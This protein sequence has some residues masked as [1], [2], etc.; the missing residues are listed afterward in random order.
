MAVK[1]TMMSTIG[2]FTATTASS[3]APYCGGLLEKQNNALFYFT[4]T[5]TH[6]ELNRMTLNKKSQT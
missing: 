1:K 4:V 2:T 6:L 3:T 5:A